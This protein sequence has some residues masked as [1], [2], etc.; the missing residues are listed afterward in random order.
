MFKRF[1]IAALC[2][3]TA[4]AAAS[5]SGDEG[6]PARNPDVITADEL[7]APE[8]MAGDALSAIQRL[9]PRFLM[10]QGQK[11]SSN[12]SAGSVKV[13]IDGAPLLGVDQLH[14]VQTS[15]I[16]E[17]RYLSA[18]DASQRFGTAANAG[19]VILIKSK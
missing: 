10:V 4:C 7:T 2:I 1:A 15:S 3:S 5:T 11:S 18:S 6:K 13:S 19:A 16:K 12:T 17:I 8:I 14:N 9:R